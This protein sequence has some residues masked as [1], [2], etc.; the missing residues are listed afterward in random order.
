MEAVAPIS[1]DA[2]IELDEL[3][4]SPHAR[5]LVVCETKLAQPG[6]DDEP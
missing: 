3:P 1:E 6:E 5:D 4:A 2:A